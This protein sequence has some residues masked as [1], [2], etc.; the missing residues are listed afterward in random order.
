MMTVR[1]TATTPVDI[2]G[3]GPA[4]AL[5]RACASIVRIITGSIAVSRIV[6]STPIM[7]QYQE[8]TSVRARPQRFI[9]TDPMP[10]VTSAAARN[11]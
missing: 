5:C 2:S 4:G 9:R 7:S 10:R 3:E 6:M 1:I 8:V 11:A